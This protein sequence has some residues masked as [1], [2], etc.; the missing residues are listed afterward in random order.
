MLEQALLWTFRVVVLGML[1]Y[2]AKGWW[3]E[4]NKP[5]SS[6]D[7]YITLGELVT[8]CK[9]C[10]SE[11]KEDRQN[12]INHLDELIKQR[13]KTGDDRFEE[14]QSLQKDLTSAINQLTQ[15]VTVLQTKVQAINGKTYN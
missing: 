14:I 13:L 4:R 10:H 5:R 8:R 15:T 1:L 12:G 9:E 7:Q 6:E 2:F 3:D 11:M